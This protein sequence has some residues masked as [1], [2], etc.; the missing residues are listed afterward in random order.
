VTVG[1]GKI[2]EHLAVQRVNFLGEQAY[3]VAAGKQSIE[4]FASLGMATLQY[5]VIHEPEAARQKGAFTRWQAVGRVLGLVAEHEFVVDQQT[6][7]DRLQRSSNSQI[8]CGKEP[9]EGHQ[10]QARV[11]AGGAVRLHKAV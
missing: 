3:V 9:H 1:L 10:Q 6:F 4:E 7:L 5:V 11:E 8:G 2:T